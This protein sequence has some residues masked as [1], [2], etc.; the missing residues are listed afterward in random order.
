M[1]PH[2]VINDDDFEYSEVHVLQYG[3]SPK[4]GGADRADSNPF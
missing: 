3:P 1:L 4:D 2:G